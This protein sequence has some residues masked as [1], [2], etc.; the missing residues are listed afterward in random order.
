MSYLE[1]TLRWFAVNRIF[2]GIQKLKKKEY[3]VFTLIIL[4][5]TSVNTILSILY[6]LNLFLG[7]EF[8]QTMLILEM[9]IA[10]AIIIS[11]VLIGKIKNF[12]L[13]IIIFGI[14]MIFFAIAYFSLEWT[15][16]QT[17]FTVFKVIFFFAWILISSIS[18]FFLI[19]YFF[20]SFPKK[21]IT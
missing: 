9:F 21:V 13:Y 8:I 14:V 5:I 1:R 15:Y 19:M 6:H 11:G 7:L 18:L 17:T 12:I 3:I 16:S 10:F 2:G 20:T 4:L